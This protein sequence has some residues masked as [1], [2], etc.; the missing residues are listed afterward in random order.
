MSGW[1]EVEQQRGRN[2]SLPSLPCCGLLDA[3]FSGFS[4]ADQSA[5]GAKF[6]CSWVGGSEQSEINDSELC[7]DKYR[8]R[9]H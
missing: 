1:R 6:P 3:I 8:K 7:F 4:N 2:K 5:L 9:Y